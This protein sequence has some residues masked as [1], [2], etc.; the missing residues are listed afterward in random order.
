MITRYRY[1]RVCQKSWC[2]NESSVCPECKSVHLQP[3]KRSRLFKDI[4][5]SVYKAYDSSDYDGHERRITSSRQEE[6][7]LERFNLVRWEDC[8][9]QRGKPEAQKDPN[10]QPDT[11]MP[12]DV[13][14]D[15]GVKEEVLV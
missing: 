8:D 12:E 15:F 14:I 4:Q 6:K 11:P 10:C 3:P 7:L 13:S 2:V 1:C 5:I 9:H